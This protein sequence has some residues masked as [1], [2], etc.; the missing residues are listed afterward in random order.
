MDR[1]RKK[2]IEPERQVYYVLTQKW[3]LDINRKTS[4]QSTTVENLDNKEEP[5]RDIYGF[6]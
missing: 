4:L 1:S 6:T 2:H 5:K 3:L